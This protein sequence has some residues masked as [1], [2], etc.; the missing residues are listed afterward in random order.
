[1]DDNFTFSGVICYFIFFFFVDHFL[2]Y[3]SVMVLF[4]IIMHGI[5]LCWYTSCG[6][7]K[8]DIDVVLLGVWFE[9]KCKKSKS[10]VH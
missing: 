6:A 1:M 7:D 10:F 2:F 3:L 4:V 9:S 5:I 8:N